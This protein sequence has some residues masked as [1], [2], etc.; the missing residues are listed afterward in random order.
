M[1]QAAY[2]YKIYGLHIHCNQE[3]TSIPTYTQPFGQ[4]DV[5]IWIGATPPG[6]TLH[7]A[8]WVPHRSIE[9]KRPY[10]LG[11]SPLLRIYEA[12]GGAYILLR[13]RSGIGFAVD[14][15][16]RNVWADPED[17]EQA[18]MVAPFLLGPVLGFVLR[19]RGFVVLHGAAIAARQR[20]L[21]VCG[22]SGIGKS[23]LAAQF[24]ANGH[25]ILADDLA[26]VTADDDTHSIQPGY[27]RLRL[28]PASIDAVAAPAQQLIP[29]MPVFGKQYL[30]LDNADEPQ[31]QDEA[32][33][34]GAILLL[35]RRRGADAP[36]DMEQVPSVQAILHLISNTYMNYL[37]DSDMRAAEF[38][39]LTE[40]IHNTPIYD[41]FVPTDLTRLPDLY[42]MIMQRVAW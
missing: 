15:T 33:P 34:L 18:S 41:L 35:K 9:S 22:P 7:S 39:F 13:Y 23:T 10:D 2:P 29:I 16:G 12:R 38:R 19:L 1:P 6:L 4:P 21:V 28:R 17:D 40:L 30:A 25:R 3:I 14:S 27:P 5:N 8:E 11:D 20:T 36:L 24:A 37:L 26:V 32:L 42:E 31:F